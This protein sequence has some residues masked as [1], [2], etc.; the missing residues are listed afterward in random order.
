MFIYNSICFIF[1]SS[2]VG[3]IFGV[4]NLVRNVWYHPRMFRI[5][6]VLRLFWVTRVLIQIL[7]NQ[8]YIELHNETLF[9][10]VKYLL[11]QGSDTFTAVL[12]MACWLSFFCKC[13]HQVFLWV[14]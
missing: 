5:S 10:A 3:V 8:A 14:K 7:H 2:N 9:G 12:G 4:I 13:I 1:Y 6:T 11:V